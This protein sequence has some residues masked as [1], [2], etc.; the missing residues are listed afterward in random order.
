MSQ[1]DSPRVIVI[2][3]GFAGIEC[4]KK[5]RRSGVQITLI[6]KQN[7]HLF[8][9]LLYQVATAAL[10]P[11]NI[12]APIREVFANDD[13][14]RV[15]LSEVIDID[16]QRLAVTLASREELQ[17]DYIVVASGLIPQYFGNEWSSIAPPLKTVGDALEIRERF[18][19]AFEVAEMLDTDADRERHLTFVVIGGGPTGVE[20]AGALAELSSKTLR[21]EFRRFD[22]RSAK[23]ILVEGQDRLLP[24]MHASLSARA[25]KD[26][27]QLG[28]EVV[29]GS[30][31]S[32]LEPTRV[33]LDNGR[34]ITSSNVI[35][36]AG[37]A[38]SELGGKVESELARDGR[39]EVAPDLSVPEHPNVF[40]AGDL[41]RV[42]D[43]RS[44][45]EVPG[46]APAALQMG[47][48]LGRLIAREARTTR[49]GAAPP[50]RPRFRYLDK[51]QLATIGR[52]KAVADIRGWRFAG[53][54]AFLLWAVVH[55]FF[56]IGYRNRI[57]TMLQWVWHYVLYDRGARIIVKRERGA[58]AVAGVPD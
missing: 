18:L 22:P 58:P 11:A 36:A 15:V 3:A 37:V 30:L 38:G 9:P 47:A 35:W 31:A 16:P 8:Q 27:E 57:L 45:A 14:V 44:N 56:L 28:V 1:Q 19:T 2:G 20:M 13:N 10:S 32:E 21:S 39:V 26:L 33:V 55:I 23:I 54:P 17:A 50:A 46:V 40:V 12:A 41:A 4:V 48:F 43:P 52:G 51:G 5:L 7:H 49:R 24:T 42:V 6:D 25:K 29:L 53:V 34:V